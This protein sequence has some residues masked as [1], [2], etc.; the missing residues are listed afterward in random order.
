MRKV[1]DLLRLGYKAG[2]IRFGYETLERIRGRYII[3]AATDLSE[4]T[5]KHI[6][7]KPI[8]K[9]YFYFTKET[10][11]KIFNKNN[12]GVVII[13]YDSIG[14]EIEKNLDKL[15]KEAFVE[16]HYGKTTG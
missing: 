7:S 5:K 2:S 13:K 11:S 4:R 15:V 1:V 3:L 16:E 10:L 12:L 8:Y 14:K 9:V 6:L